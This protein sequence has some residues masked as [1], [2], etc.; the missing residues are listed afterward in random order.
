KKAVVKGPV[1]EIIVR[2]IDRCPDCKANDIGLTQQAF[3]AVAGELG[4]GR[5]SV[6]WYFMDKEIV[7]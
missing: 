3:I 2:F 6:V 5:T 4:I 1:G 7:F